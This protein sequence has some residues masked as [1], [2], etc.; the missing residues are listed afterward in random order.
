MIEAGTIGGAAAAA[1]AAETDGAMGEGDA[2]MMGADAVTCSSDESTMVCVRSMIEAR[3]E[4]DA[5][6][7]VRAAD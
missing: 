3:F 6:V 4:M 1:A 5:G 7:V 2:T